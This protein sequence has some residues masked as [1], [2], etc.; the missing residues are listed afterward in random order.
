MATKALPDKRAETAQAAAEII[1]GLVQDEGNYVVTTD[2]GNEF[3]GLERALP[4]VVARHG[5]GWGEWTD[6]EKTLYA[7]EIRVRRQQGRT[8]VRSFFLHLLEL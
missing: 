6:S 5:G 3:Q 8:A 2:Q 7:V 4:G 1:P